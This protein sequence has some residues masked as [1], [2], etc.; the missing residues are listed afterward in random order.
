MVRRAGGGTLLADET[1]SG[2][3]WV[4]YNDVTIKDNR[5]LSVA[6]GAVVQAQSWGRQI[7]Q[8]VGTPAYLLT[9][10][11]TATLTATATRTTTLTAT[12]TPTLTPN[13]T[14]TATVMATPTWIATPITAPSHR[15]YLPLMFKET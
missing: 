13:A 3:D 5:T 10:T 12:F 15:L 7:L 1:W 11:M 2:G 6:N 8:W 9:A 4:L 14:S